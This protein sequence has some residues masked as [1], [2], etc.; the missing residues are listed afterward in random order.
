MFEDI[1]YSLGLEIDPRTA[2]VYF[3]L[4]L[5]LVFGVLAQLT[6]FCLRRALIGERAERSSAA[7][8]WAAA[9]AVALLGT[10]A[11]VSIGWIS[12]DEHRFHVSEVPILAIAIGGVLFG[13]GTV[14]ARGCISRLT[15]LSGTG[16][17]RAL[18]ALPVIAIFAH[19]TLKGVLAPL[20]VELGSNTVDLGSWTTLGSWPGGPWLWTAL[21]VALAGW[22]VVRSGASLGALMG[23]AALGALVP[24]GWVGTGFLL[25]DEFD[26]IALESLSL[27]SPWTETLFWSVASSSIA[28]SF[29]VGLIGGILA[30]GLLVALGSGQFRWQSFESPA[31][32]GRTLSGAVLMGV[33]GVLAGGCSIGAGL[34]GIPTL[35]V[36]A[37][38]ALASIIAGILVAHAVQT[39]LTGAVA[40]PA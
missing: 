24:L 32:T 21:I 40:A 25:Y 37:V 12:F 29:G 3:G 16:N 31:Q 34:A 6:R 22:L 14:L 19:M 33:G 17:L 36:A 35:S 10:Q 9:L 30:G 20:R 11:A 18:I 26:P 39:R 13:I 4:A 7:G 23:G 8:V 27:T 1:T 38:L 28:P 5:G 15:V 2:S